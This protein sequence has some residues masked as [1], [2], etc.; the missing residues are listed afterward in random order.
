MAR[1]ATL[2]KQQ[3]QTI[4]RETFEDPFDKGRF[5]GFVKNLLNHIDESKSFPK[6]L[7]GSYIKESFR[8]RIKSYDRIGRFIDVEGK[9]IDIL[10]VCLH[11]ETSLT[12]A[13]TSLRNF[14]A[15]YLNGDY[16]SSSFKDAALIAFYSEDSPDW[17]FSLVTIDYI[18][19]NAKV[20]KEFSSAKRFSFLVGMN[21]NSH[22]AQS[23]LYP[24]I[25]DENTI[26][27][28]PSLKKP[29]T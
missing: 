29:S 9:V 17:R 20:K 15:G 21:E 6:P 12:Q 7:T 10:T 13:R 27:L 23:K 5:V 25:A 28:L 26:P 8:E 3:A 24:I 16:G 2:D 1:D 14:A 18:F 22:T 4:V 19:D 11:R